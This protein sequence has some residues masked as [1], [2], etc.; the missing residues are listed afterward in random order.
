MPLASDTELS[1][2]WVNDHE[3]TDTAVDLV[4]LFCYDKMGDRIVKNPRVRSSVCIHPERDFV[5][6]ISEFTYRA[7]GDVFE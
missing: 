5:G 6:I 2:G 7:H 4:C 3:H 1:C